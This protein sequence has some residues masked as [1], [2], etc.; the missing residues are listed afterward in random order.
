MTDEQKKAQC[1]ERAAQLIEDGVKPALVRLV[2][3]LPFDK[4]IDSDSSVSESVGLEKNRLN[5]L[6]GTLQDEIKDFVE[7]L[8]SSGAEG[9]SIAEVSLLI[10]N[11]A[12]L[13]PEH[14]RFICVYLASKIGEELRRGDRK[15]S[16][17][18]RKSGRRRSSGG[19]MRRRRPRPTDDNDE[20]DDQ[21]LDI[22]KN[23][24]GATD[25]DLED[26]DDED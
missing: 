21:I 5:K 8:R 2:T 17:R 12:V 24:L 26:K 23:L 20:D 22:L 13:S 6:I 11:F 18:R 3:Q 4:V 16:K 10:E 15:R 1:D 9:V 19:S 25:E 7:G 14:M